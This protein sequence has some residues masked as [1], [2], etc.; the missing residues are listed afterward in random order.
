MFSSFAGCKDSCIQYC[1]SSQVNLSHPLSSFVVQIPLFCLRAKFS[2][3]YYEKI[4]REIFVCPSRIAKIISKN[5]KSLLSGKGTK[6]HLIRLLPDRFYLN[7]LTVGL[8]S[9][10]NSEANIRIPPNNLYRMKALLNS[11]HMSLNHFVQCYIQHHMK[12]R[13]VERCVF[14]LMVFLVFPRLL[15][16]RHSPLNCLTQCMASPWLCQ[17]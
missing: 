9:D 2:L 15:P 11:F 12:V 7:G 1:L 4:P 17:T 6:E 3:I 13:T 16:R 8:H 5:P 14:P 10:A